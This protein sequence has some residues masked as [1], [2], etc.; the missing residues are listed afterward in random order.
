M[1]LSRRTFMHAAAGLTAL[2]T[3]A[4]STWAAT[5]PDRPV[6]I[7]VGFPAGQSA[8]IAARLI[9]QWLSERL[10]Q[11]VIIE[12]RPGAGTNIATEAVAH[13]NPDGYTLLCASAPNVIN[14]SLYK[15]LKFD[16]VR[17]IAPIASLV[18]VPFVLVVGQS[19]AVKTVG[20]LI[21]SAK[22]DPGKLNYASSGIGTVNHMAGELFKIMAGVDMAHVPYKGTA[23]AITDLMDGQVQMMFA[24]ASAIEY[25]KNGMLR[26]LAVSTAKR[27]DEL[28]GVPTVG[29]SVSGFEVSGFLGIAAP[30]GIP[31]EIVARLNGENNAG[32]ADATLS[33]RFKAM[34]YT[35]FAST[36]A[37]FGNFIAEE[38]AK[39]TKV[40]STAGIKSE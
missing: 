40:V 25:V 16:F 28:P 24:D 12:N 26:A 13:A 8:D 15:G 14:G 21:A 34:G 10:G 2:P 27:L 19:S 4:A 29:E 6:R 5:Y 9:G 33:A 3:F 38:T 22:A 35:V 11:P 17:D 1:K 23:P 20:E 39:W 30:K 31:A 18:R 37:D 36:S 32:L 7:L